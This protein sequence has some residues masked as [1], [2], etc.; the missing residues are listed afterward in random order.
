MN[1]RQACGRAAALL[2]ALALPG[3]RRD[4][5][6]AP[7]AAPPAP[8]FAWKMV[9]A[10]PR[11]YPGLGSGAED[12]ARRVTAMSGGRLTITV[13]AAGERVPAAALFDAVSRGSA[14]LGH[15]AAHHWQG[16]IA[17]APFFSSLPFGLSA[18]EMHAWLQH[19]GG[20]ALW[21]EAYAP[22]GV[23]PLAVGNT[24][25]QLGGWFNKEIT[26]LQDLEGLRVRM[27]GLGGEVLKRFAATIVALSEGDVPGALYDGSIDAAAGNGPYADLAVGLPQFARFCYYPGWQAPQALIELLINRKA[28][29][30]LP[31]DLQA[32]VEEAAHGATQRMRE[33]YAA[34]NAQALAELKQQGV[35]FKRYPEE[36]LAALHHEAAQVLE[37]LASQNALNG[38]IWASLKAFRAPADELYRLSAKAL[39]HWR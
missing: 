29:D 3:C 39:D 20:Q 13:Y 26:T 15:S 36:L 10:W 19:G 18:T 33:E 27:P 35:V 5:P 30:A 22:F 28:W 25:M 24:G 17:A 6:P 14:E 34:G 2:A 23:R 9:T 16:R 38:R 12:F 4:A 11:D 7:A 32:I 31:A 1:R 37:Q 8:T 21:E